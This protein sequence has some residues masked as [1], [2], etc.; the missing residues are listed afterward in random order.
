[1]K[2]FTKK[3]SNDKVALG[4]IYEHYVDSFDVDIIYDYQS[5]RAEECGNKFYYGELVEKLAKYEDLGTVEDFEEILKLQEIRESRPYYK[6]YLEELRVNDER[7]LHPDFDDI[8][9]RYFDLREELEVY[10]RALEM[11]SQTI[12]EILGGPIVM[13]GA[14]ANK[15]RFE[16]KDTEYFLEQ[17]RKELE[18]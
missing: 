12:S 17:S 7:L 6:K 10:K 14:I 2:R 3:L 13:G 15:L 4:K 1:M 18:V 9:K 16:P 11:A 8:Y 5:E